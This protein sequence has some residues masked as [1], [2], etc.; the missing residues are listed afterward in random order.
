MESS[1]EKKILV[2]EIVYQ[3]YQAA[4]DGQFS[5]VHP[6]CRVISVADVMKRTEQWR[7]AGNAIA[8]L[9]LA[10]ALEKV[11]KEPRQGGWHVVQAGMAG[12]TFIVP[13]RN[14]ARLNA[15]Q[16]TKLGMCTCRAC[17]HQRGRN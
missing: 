12:H 7:R 13:L 8:L 10:D 1:G 14:V 3:A 17:Q 6:K 5:P 9:R 11:A 16:M 4:F 2:S 15:L